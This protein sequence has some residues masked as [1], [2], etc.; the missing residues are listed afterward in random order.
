MMLFPPFRAAAA[1]L[2]LT[3]VP[4]IANAA[5]PELE[6]HSPPELAPL[7]QRLEASIDR[8]LLAATAD[9]IGLTPPGP[10]IPVHIAPE[11]SVLARRAPS[12][13]VAYATPGG[14]IVLL[15][16]RVPGYP[17]RRI[18]TVL[19]HEVAHILI[20]RASRGH[21][22]PRWFHE[23][24]ALYAARGWGL[25]DRSRLLWGTLRGRDSA[26]VTLEERFQGGRDSAS[27]AYAFA[28]AFVRYLVE[29][30]GRGAPARILDGVGQGLAFP[31]AVKDATGLTLAQ[32]ETAYFRH[33]DFWNKWVPFL[34]SSTTLW[35]LISLLAIYAFKRRRA[36]DA[37]ILA[38][39]ADEE[40]SRRLA[41][42]PTDDWV[43]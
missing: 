18:E 17:N 8:D 33:L 23:G 27:R 6:F 12:W 41:E 16:S 20:Y 22:V 39:W 21:S 29:E 4:T 34:T 15:P 10:P 36:K 24:L 1:L 2:I 30:H 26:L 3:L 42:M 38:R 19:V 14:H 32:V 37:E 5:A 13:G 11:G 43:H 35:I 9:L 28:G 31:A 40:E 7:A 25:E